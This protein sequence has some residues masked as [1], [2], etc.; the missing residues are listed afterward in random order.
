MQHGNAFCETTKYMI[1]K[2]LGVVSYGAA[3]YIGT[4]YVTYMLR[5]V[6]TK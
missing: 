6:H 1:K 3:D 4:K 5:V 2:G